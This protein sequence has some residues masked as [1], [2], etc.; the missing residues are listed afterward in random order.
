MTTTTFIG[1]AISDTM[2]PEGTMTRTVITPAEAQAAIESGAQSVANPSHATTLDVIKRKCGVVI[3][4]PPSAPQVNLN[5]GDVLIVVQARLPRLAEGQ[6]HTD[7]T[8]AAAPIT[9]AKWVIG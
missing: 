7:E 4:V 1:L 2:F 5:A 9:F 3:P 6:V 8:V